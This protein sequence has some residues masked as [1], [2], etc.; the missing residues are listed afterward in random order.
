MIGPRI[1]I[2][3]ERIIVLTLTENAATVIKRLATRTPG[4]GTSGLRIGSHDDTLGVEIAAAPEPGDHVVE[5]RGARVFVDSKASPRCADKE[6]DAV[7]GE[8]T[9]RFALRTRK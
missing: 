2:G 5:N 3:D 9:V 8:G 1:T 6:L 4:S 7:V